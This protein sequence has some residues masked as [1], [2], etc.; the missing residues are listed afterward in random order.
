MH[1]VY[2]AEDKLVLFYDYLVERTESTTTTKTITGLEGT[3]AVTGTTMLGKLLSVL[4]LA[5]LELKAQVSGTGKVSFEKEVVSDF[6]TPQKLKALLL[7]LGSEG[8][9]QVLGAGD[10]LETQPTLQKG[11]QILLTA[12]LKTDYERREEADVLVMKQVVLSGSLAGF[13]LAVQASLQYLRSPN[14]WYRW[15]DPI[16]MMVFGTLIK[17]H[18][19]DKF[20]EVD[21]IV[22]AYAPPT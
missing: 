7:K 8:T 10:S 15:D 2:F 19:A 18:T 13:T 9:L 22:L 12:E 4:G 16:G 11:K 5:D 17:V 20:M 6:T 1:F 14:A 21:P 3:A